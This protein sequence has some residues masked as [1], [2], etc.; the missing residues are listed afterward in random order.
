MNKKRRYILY[1]LLPLLFFELFGCQ[2]KKP[3]DQQFIIDMQHG[4]ENRWDISDNSS[5]DNTAEYWT[6]CI[7]AELTEIS[8][9]SKKKFKNKDLGQ[10]AKDYI[11]ILK[12]SKASLKY[13]DDDDKFNAKNS[14][15]VYQ[16]SAIIYQLHKDYK[17]NFDE[18]YKKTYQQF[19]N[20]GKTY[21]DSQKILKSAKFK[22]E[23]NDY[24]YKTYSTVIKNPSDNTFKYFELDVNLNDKDGVTVETQSPST[25]NWEPG[26]KHRFEF[27]TSKKF[28]KIDVKSCSWSFS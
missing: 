3:T 23:K 16:R 26:T 15:I 20:D 6:K 17:L 8:P 9:Y 1:V 21:L 11:S 28:K 12:E 22:L 24:G 18:K 4:L 7:N 13:L 14:D 25:D 2:K 5:D 10:K 27:M 19:Y